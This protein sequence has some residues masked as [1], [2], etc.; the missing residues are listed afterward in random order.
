MPSLRHYHRHMM[1]P[2]TQIT[3]DFQAL[4][5]LAN[6]SE[7]RPL[8]KH[9]CS[10]HITRLHCCIL[11]GAEAHQWRD[12]QSNNRSSSFE[13]CREKVVQKRIII[14]HHALLEWRADFVKRERPLIGTSEH[15]SREVVRFYHQ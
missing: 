3:I 1:P 7:L 8:C 11:V 2:G 15:R 13:L 4:Y 10:V 6:I 9:N 5:R 12:S 14:G